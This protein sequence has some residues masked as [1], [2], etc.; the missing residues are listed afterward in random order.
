M[1][2]SISKTGFALVAAVTMF[3]LAGLLPAGAAG[4]CG[5]TSIHAEGYDTDNEAK[6]Q[7][8]GIFGWENA[9]KASSYGAAYANWSRAQQKS[10]TCRKT[11]KYYTCKVSAQPCP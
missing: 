4:G 1:S 2:I 5:K 6:A 9:V 3:S 8:A 10:V 7:G 11:G